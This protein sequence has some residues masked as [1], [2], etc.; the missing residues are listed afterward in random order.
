V[1]GNGGKF[2]QKSSISLSKQQDFIAAHIDNDIFLISAAI[3]LKNII[4]LL[5]YVSVQ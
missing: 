1:A 3:C 2:F 4:I 5:Y